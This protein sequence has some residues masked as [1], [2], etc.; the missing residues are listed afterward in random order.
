MTSS[1]P[2]LPSPGLPLSLPSLSLLI[3]S[4]PSPAFSLPLLSL[5]S[6][7]F[8]FPLLSLPFHYLLSSDPFVLFPPHQLSLA[9]STQYLTITCYLKIPL[10]VALLHSFWPSIFSTFPERCHYE[11][12]AGASNRNHRQWSS[13]LTT[14]SNLDLNHDNLVTLKLYLL[15]E[16]YNL[17]CSLMKLVNLHY[18]YAIKS[19]FNI[20]IG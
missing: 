19:T 3:L 18:W 14:K 5:L 10:S 9:S 2:S 15:S 12:R 17:L 20:A 4:L 8:S 11:V 7:A 16:L 6:P 13:W 1:T